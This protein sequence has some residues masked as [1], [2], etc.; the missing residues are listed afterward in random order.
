MTCPGAG[1]LPGKSGAPRSGGEEAEPGKQPG[2][3]GAA[4]RWRKADEVADHFPQGDCECGADLADA[5]DLGVVRSYQQ[6]D[7]TEPQPSRRYQHDLHKTRCACGRVHVAPRPAGDMVLHAEEAAAKRLAAFVSDAAI[8]RMIADAQDAGFDE[9][10]LRSGPAGDKKYVHGAFTELYSAFW[11]GT[12]SLETMKEAGIVPSFAGIVVSDRYA[13]YYSETWANF[14]GHQACAAHLIRDFA[15]C[16]ETY[17]GAGWPEQARRAL[18]GLI[19]CWPPGWPPYP[20]S[21]ARRTARNRG[22]AARCPNS[23]ATAGTTSSAS[24][25]TR[26]YGPLTTSASGASAR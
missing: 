26:P 25:P 19:R 6:E 4:M 24:P 18:R 21:P 1:R 13:G 11:L 5:A 16:A 17:P 2:S 12:R 8:D 20:V 14:A 15:G 10:T 7:V 23:A 9:T 3:P 22:P